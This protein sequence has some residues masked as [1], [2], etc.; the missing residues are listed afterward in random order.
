[1]SHC[2]YTSN[3]FISV[4]CYLPVYPGTIFSTSFWSP[5]LWVLLARSLDLEAESGRTGRMSVRTS[6]P[7]L[8]TPGFLS[9]LQV[10]L[11]KVSP[12]WYLNWGQKPPYLKHRREKITI[13]HCF[14]DQ[15]KAVKTDP[16]YG[17]CSA[18]FKTLW[19]KMAF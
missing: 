6:L 13:W 18:N 1:M 4:H 11:P 10:V 14:K 3:S 19:D 7:E 2:F 5:Q 9:K 17:L 16:D 8:A 12:I 15:M